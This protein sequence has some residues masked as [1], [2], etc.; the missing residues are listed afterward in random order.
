MFHIFKYLRLMIKI[1]IFHALD[2]SML[3]YHAYHED[4]EIYRVLSDY[5]IN[6][7]IQ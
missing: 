2:V 7:R 5:E 4:I 1:K 6:H 3:L